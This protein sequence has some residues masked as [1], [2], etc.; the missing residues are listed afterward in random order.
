MTDLEYLKVATGETDEAILIM[1]LEKS[2]SFILSYTGRT[3]MIQPLEYPKKELAV[4]YYNR[5]GTEG[6]KGRSEAGE[7]R[8]FEEAPKQIYDTL[9]RYRLAAIGGKTYEA[10][11]KQD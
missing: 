8:T 9:N 4:I 6:E 2:E 10:S 1:L 11:K 7:S 5:I 3:N